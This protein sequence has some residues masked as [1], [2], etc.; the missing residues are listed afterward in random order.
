MVRF[1]I[2]LSDG[3]GDGLNL[4]KVGTQGANQMFI[5]RPR[6]M[7]Q[8]APFPMALIHFRI[9]FQSQEALGG[10][11]AWGKS[12]L[13]RYLVFMVEIQRRLFFVKMFHLSLASKDLFWVSR[14]LMPKPP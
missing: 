3:F 12:E 11:L 7:D 6:E 4:A 10:I 14:G 2:R 1:G 13:M 9:L 5:L 8:Q